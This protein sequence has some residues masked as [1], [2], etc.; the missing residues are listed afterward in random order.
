M[1]Y[2]V[3]LITFFLENALQPLAQGHGNI[4]IV[5][6]Q[7]M[8]D[9]EDEQSDHGN[10]RQLGS[11]GSPNYER[12]DRKE[13]YVL[14]EPRKTVPR[15]DARYYPKHC[16]DCPEYFCQIAHYF[17][18]T[19]LSDRQFLTFITGNY[20]DAV[21]LGQSLHLLMR[22]IYVIVEPAAETNAQIEKEVVYERPGMMGMVWRT[23]LYLTP[24]AK[25]VYLHRL[26][27]HLAAHIFG[28]FVVAQALKARL[29]KFMVSSPLLKA[30]FGHQF[31]FDPMDVKGSRFIAIER[32][33]VRG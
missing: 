3:I 31:R 32:I 30:Y 8:Q 6:G 21:R 33:F 1:H 27:R 22:S 2:T 11:I 25:N 28:G 19:I 10:V 14:Q 5:G 24:S 18:F 4:G 17:D 23:G 7:K 13:G 20:V 9:G 29:A 26:F 15:L 12:Q 16:Y